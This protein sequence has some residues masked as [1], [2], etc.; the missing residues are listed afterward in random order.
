[1]GKAGFWLT[2]LCKASL[3]L[4]NSLWWC[5][6]SLNPPNEAG[7]YYYYPRFA[8]EETEVC[9]TREWAVSHVGRNWSWFSTQPACP[10]AQLS[11]ALHTKG[12]QSRQTSLS[13]EESMTLKNKWNEMELGNLKTM[14]N[15]D[16]SGGGSI[17]I[18]II[19]R[20]IMTSLVFAHPC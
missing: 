9:S 20:C 14:G 19:L 2:L 17:S 6:T 4:L 1:M 8:G 11:L 18:F 13:Q 16:W 3:E 7:G 12:C 5:V 10:G 15:P